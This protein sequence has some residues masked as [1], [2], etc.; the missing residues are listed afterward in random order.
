[1]TKAHLRDLFQWYYDHWDRSWPGLMPAQLPSWSASKKM[2]DLDSH[3]RIK[4]YK[5]MCIEAQKFVDE[6][7]IE[8]AMRWLGFMQGVLWHSS[9]FTLDELKEHS[10]PKEE[11]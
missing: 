6:G 8:K 2:S 9:H 5:F 3:E 11:S 1:M 10:R 7:R 4:H